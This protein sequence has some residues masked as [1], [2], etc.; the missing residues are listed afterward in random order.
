[1]LHAEL[2][3]RRTAVEE[4]YRRQCELSNRITSVDVK[5]TAAD[6]DAALEEVAKLTAALLKL[7]NS[8]GSLEALSAAAASSQLGRANGRRKAYD[9]T[10]P[11][12]DGWRRCAWTGDAKMGLRVK[13]GDG[14]LLVA[15][16]R[17][18]VYDANCEPL[19]LTPGWYVEEVAG[20]PVTTTAEFRTALETVDRTGGQEFEV[21]FSQGEAG[22]TTTV[23]D[24]RKLCDE[25]PYESGRKRRPGTE[26]ERVSSSMYL[27]APPRTAFASHTR[28]RPPWHHHRLLPACPP[29]CPLPFIVIRMCRDEDGRGTW[30]TRWRP[31][32]AGDE[33]VVSSHESTSTPVPVPVTTE[34]RLSFWDYP[35][36]K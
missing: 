11:L 2:A 25:S 14:V 33:S 29:T 30:R 8:S 12:P 34:R 3:K 23:R 31:E 27:G 21:L 13:N 6:S 17:L 24:F 10:R 16:Q 26:D 1:M 4:V 36:P 18:R 5:S 35:A 28:S 19:V 15:N 9:R 32:R 7:R 22:G 20:I